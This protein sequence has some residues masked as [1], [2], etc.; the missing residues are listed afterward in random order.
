[1][2]EPKS[3]AD[4]QSALAG[5]KP[6]HAT[7]ELVRD[8][9]ILLLVGVSGAGKD[10]IKQRLLETG[11]YHHLVSHTTR[12]PRE[13]GG[14]LERDGVDYHFVT[15][16][17]ALEMLHTGEFVEVNQY[18]GNV[19]GTS[20]AEIKKAHD[21]GKIA[22]TDLEV[23]GVA[24]YKQIAP[25]VVAVFILP[26]TYE[27]WQRR[28]HSRYGVKGADPTDITRRM[29]T[30]I[31]ELQEAL[32]KPYYHFVVNEN[33]DEAV[34]AVNSI[35]HHNDEFTTID[36]SFRVWAERLLKDLQKGD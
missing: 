10:T 21:E 13:N 29:R 11:E 34:K 4:I 19:Y 24:E 31:A 23:Q 30:A 22:V 27:E 1:M 12:A 2:N 3:A 6:S 8:T 5:Y 20:V 15:E 33:V 9:P 25:S 35:A 36:Q 18:S 26:P 16:A 32:N 17:Q 28:L 14:V 7:I